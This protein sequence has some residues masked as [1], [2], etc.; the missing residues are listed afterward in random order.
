M[1]VQIRKESNSRKNCGPIWRGLFCID[2]VDCELKTLILT[3]M[4]TMLKSIPNPKVDMLRRML[5]VFYE[6][7]STQSC[8]VI[9]VLLFATGLF[10]AAG[11]RNAGHVSGHLTA[12][13]FGAL[14]R[15][16]SQ[17]RL[18]FVSGQVTDDEE[19]KS[20]GKVERVSSDTEKNFELPPPCQ[21]WEKPA[22]ALFC[23]GRQNGYI[24][25]CGCTGLA[26]AKGG[27]SRRHTF[28]NQLRARG[29]DVVP[30]DVGNQVRRFGAQAEIKL[31]TTAT[32]LRLMNYEAIA[33]GPDD[34]RLSVGELAAAIVG[35]GAGNDSIFIS[36]NANMLD[37]NPRL[38]IVDV[39]GKK[40]GI[41]AILGTEEQKKVNSPD[42][43]FMPPKDAIA[44][45]LPELQA[46]NCDYFV[47][48]SHASTDESNELAKA[49][50]AFSVVITAGGAGEPTAEPLHVDGSN[51][52]I[53]QVGTKGMY[54]GVLGFYPD[55]QQPWRYER[56][57]LDSRFSDSEGVLEQFA[58]YQNQLRDLGFAGLGIRAVPHPS[59]RQ[60][61]GHETCGECHTTAYE[62]FENTPHFHATDSIAHPTERSDI[63]RIYDPEC[64]S[65]HVTGWNPQEYFP[66]ESGY[67]GFEQSKF[68][69]SNG[70]ENCHGPGSAHVAAENGD[71]DV[72]E[73]EIE[74]RRDEMKITLEATKKTK[75]YDCHD[76]DNSPEFEFDSYWE[77]V[78]HEGKD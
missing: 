36:A 74:K 53:I 13:N 42:I 66:Y 35:N 33:L 38:R 63:P 10:L 67:V 78:K 61:V 46:A 69:H 48:L 2:L 44:S 47:L 59:K 65:C 43:Q 28:L 45:V 7:R 72:T 37:L 11:S 76:L 68:L 14:R 12:K 26:N 50:P 15:L 40:L 49:F 4:S 17:S 58:Q 8:L 64:L 34:L 24:E 57:E 41:V 31:Q 27:L 73:K 22:F 25:P 29:W 51:A 9:S 21:D 30:L 3:P 32:L 54:V 55:A 70:C 19:E 77:E 16:P 60:F 6:S 52:H 5:N 1:F 39:A 18:T 56:V 20:D 23:T 62:I 75:C 71:V